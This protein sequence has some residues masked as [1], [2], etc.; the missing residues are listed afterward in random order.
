MF[1]GT[2]PPKPLIC[3]SVSN[4]PGA[5]LRSQWADPTGREPRFSC[6]ISSFGTTDIII[7][8]SWF[9]G[10]HNRFTFRCCH[11]PS[12]LKIF[13]GISGKQK[14]LLPIGKQGLE[15]K[16]LL[17]TTLP[18]CPG[19]DWGSV[20]SGTASPKVPGRIHSR[21]W[22]DRGGSRSARSVSSSSSG[23]MCF[24]KFSSN[25]RRL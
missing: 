3:K 9:V 17:V 4:C 5:R 6:A 10:T 13:W 21:G 15:R 20:H 8:T 2:P 24:C 12:A 22:R 11:S 25:V 14:T 18:A 19:Y 1:R 16:L 7:A 23:L